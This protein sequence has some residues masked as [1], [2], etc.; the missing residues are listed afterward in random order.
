M[1]VEPGKCVSGRELLA[2][3]FSHLRSDWLW[4]FLYGILLVLCGIA[5]IIFPAVFSV[6]A[7]LILAIVLMVAGLATIIHSFWMGKWSGMLG[8]LFVG[9]LYFIVGMMIQSTPIKSALAFIFV[10]AAFFI[11]V[12]V[13]RVVSSL[14]IRFPYW[15]WSLL[16]GIVTFLL[17]VIIY[18]LYEKS[19]AESL[20][21]LGLLIGIEML[22]HGWVWVV[23][24][25]GI[26][27]L[28]KTTA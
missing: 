13:F 5:A 15:G 26:K 23:L 6:A 9:I 11:V 3:E 10:I 17:G 20:F 27:K 8:Q 1:N 2:Q 21:V 18:R 24:S 22:F 4:L 14:A 16:N 25:L 7:M 12:G 19:S 28:S